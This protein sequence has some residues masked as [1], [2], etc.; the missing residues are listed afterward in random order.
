M[1]WAEI[2]LDGRTDMHVIVRGGIMAAILRS[3]IL[4]LIVRPFA[5]VIGDAFILIRDNALAQTVRMSMTFLDVEGN[6]VM[7]WLSMS[8]NLNSMEHNWYILSRHIRRRSHHPDNVHNL[9][10][11]LV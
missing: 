4:E 2:S 1:A 6:S 9:I 7:N 5:G 10:D 3:D 11:A 8:P